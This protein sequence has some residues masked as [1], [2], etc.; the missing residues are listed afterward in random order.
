MSPTKYPNKKI[1]KNN[2]HRIFQSLMTF[3]KNNLSQIYVF[4]AYIYLSISEGSDDIPK[5]G[6]T[7][8]DILGLVQHC[9]LSSCLAH[10][11]K[12]G[13]QCY[14]PDKRRMSMLQP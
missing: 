5:G 1:P 10:L 14:N 7:F 12:G 4:K 8:I 13:C 11:I 9:A 6:E 3:T 2:N